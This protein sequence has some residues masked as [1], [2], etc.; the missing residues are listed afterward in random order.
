MGEGVSNT[1]A[2]I[3][4]VAVIHIDLQSL[5]KCSV[6]LVNLGDRGIPSVRSMRVDSVCAELLCRSGRRLVEVALKL[7]V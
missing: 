2:E 4:T 1:E 3:A 7:L 6:P 5:I